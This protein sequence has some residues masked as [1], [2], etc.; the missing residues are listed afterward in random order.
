MITKT[1][2]MNQDGT[3]MAWET[4][5]TQSS[6]CLLTSL[7]RNPKAFALGWE[8]LVRKMEAVGPFAP[9]SMIANA[10]CTISLFMRFLMTRLSSKHP[11]G[12]KKFGN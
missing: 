8:T 6:F 12:L 10:S 7:H 11:C 2:C 3:G 4:D 1:L 5:I 9:K